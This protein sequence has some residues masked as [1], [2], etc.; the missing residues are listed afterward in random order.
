MDPSGIVRRVSRSE[1]TEQ[2]DAEAR[3]VGLGKTRPRHP[4]S[5]EG[6]GVVRIDGEP[7]LP[8][9]DQPDSEPV[10]PSPVVTDES[11]TAGQVFPM[12]ASASSTPL[13]DRAKLG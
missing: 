9:F 4:C 5:S 3:V 2:L 6:D 12:L 8:Q 11:V 13:S 10:R 1:A 7:S